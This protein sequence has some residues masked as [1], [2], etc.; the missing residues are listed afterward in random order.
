MS[1][2]EELAPAAGPPAGGFPG[3]ASPLAGGAR[4]A[5]AP[6]AG[7][8][9]ISAGLLAGVVVVDLSRHLPGPF[10][11]R[12]LADLG[13]R[14]IKVEAPEGGDPVRRV[15]PRRLSGGGALAAMLLAGVESVALDLKMPAARQALDRLL[16]RADVLLESFRPGT[17][18]RLDLA[19]AALRAAHP[20]LVVCS[21]SGWGEEGPHARRAGHDLTYQAVAGALASVPPGSPPA[22]PVADLAGAWGAVAA[23]LAALLARARTG[24]GARIDAAL[25]D[26]AAHASLMTWAAAADGGGAV[27]E[28]QPLAGALPAYNVYET[29]DGGRLALGLLEPHLFERFLEVAGR[30]DLAPHQFRD[31]EHS[32]RLLAALVAGRTRAEWEALLAAEDLPVEPV[33][34]AAEARAHPQMAA[35]QVVTQGPDD[36][37]RLS[38]PARID[39]ARP[40]A[41]ARVPAVGEDTEAILDEI[42]VEVGEGIGVPRQSRS[43]RLPGRL[44]GRSGD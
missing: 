29:K 43:K 4:K 42:G 14:V 26:G 27:G 34:S 16:A 2:T 31:T 32:R 36:L 9:P 20:H 28:R 25:V 24:E 3:A 21:L 39:G 19:P 5:A 10:A 11:S 6:L 17:L 30:P 22:V 38:F 8:S 18:A 41:S 7:G 33:L 35:R 37:P 44:R 23:I 13:A 1:D 15:E 40:R 12:I